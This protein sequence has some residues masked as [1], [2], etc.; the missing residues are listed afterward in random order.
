MKPTLVNDG[1]DPVSAATITEITEAVTDLTTQNWPKID[2]IIT[3]K[4]NAKLSISFSV[5]ID[6][7]G[8]SPKVRTSIAF[9]DKQSDEREVF[10]DDPRQGR[11]GIEEKGGGK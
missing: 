6:R 4:D 8:K 7:S 11:L 9:S 2:K 5:K 10:I 3:T 1:L